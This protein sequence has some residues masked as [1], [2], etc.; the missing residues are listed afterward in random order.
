MKS[1]LLAI[2]I[3]LFFGCNDNIKKDIETIKQENQTLLKEN[4]EL[5]KEID[6]LKNGASVLY[7]KGKN[8]Y[9]NKQYPVALQYFKILIEKHPASNEAIDAKNLIILC[10]KEIKRIAD[11]ANAKRD[12]EIQVEKAKIAQAT[13]NMLQERDD[14]AKITWFSHKDMKDY[15]KTNIQVYFGKPDHKE[16][17]LRLKTTYHSD[18]WLFIKSMIIVVDDVQ[19][20]F[21]KIKF[22]RDHY[23]TIWEWSDLLVDD[24]LKNMIQKIANSKKTVIRFDGQQYYK[25]YTV[26]DKEK[27]CIQDVLKAFDTLKQ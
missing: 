5:K 3:F 13:S 1:L 9:D 16:P 27:K 25:D 6:E 21:E 14:I 24:S 22:E 15:F 23:S 18:S 19:Y 26:T 17:Y 7:Y 8:Y 12:K 4:D 11:E 2:S 10:D 20:P